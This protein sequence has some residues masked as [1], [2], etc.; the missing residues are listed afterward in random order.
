MNEL[1]ALW[2]D[3]HEELFC[4]V[5]RCVWNA[6]DAADVTSQI[7]L[8]ALVATGNGNGCHAEEPSTRRGWLYA[9]AKSA[10]YDF[11][12]KWRSKRQNDVDIDAC[13]EMPGPV[14]AYGQL[15]QSTVQE[16]VWRAV[17]GLNEQ[18]QAI[19]TMRIEGYSLGE[20]GDTLGIAETASKS[21]GSRAYANLRARLGET[22]ALLEA[23]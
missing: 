18:Q 4:Y 5:H 3:Y 6:D 11:T 22:M 15:I 2:N 10:I 13:A 7:Y 16:D 21:C 14:C 12:R 23:A 9:I 20:I 17:R 19:I 1:E 8:R